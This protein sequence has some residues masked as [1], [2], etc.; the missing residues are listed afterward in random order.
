MRTRT[1]TIAIIAL[2]AVPAGVLYAQDMSFVNGI[3]SGMTD[4]LD[5]ALPVLAALALAAFIWNG[6][7]FILR[8]D[9]DRAR[10]DG[11]KGMLWGVIALFVLVSVWG[12]VQ[13]LQGILDVSPSAGVQKPGVTISS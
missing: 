12:I 4:V 5:A 3:A 11:K 8:S 10:M 7:M 13:L 6:A 9:D 1:L 2:G